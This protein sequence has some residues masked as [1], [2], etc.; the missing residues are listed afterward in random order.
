MGLGFLEVHLVTKFVIVCR[1]CFGFFRG[2]LSDQVCSR[3]SWPFLFFFEVHLLTKLVVVCHG[4]FGFFAV[5]LLT[6]FVVFCIVVFQTWPQKN[7]TTW[8]QKN[9][10]LTLDLKSYYGHSS[11]CVY[12]HI[13]IPST[14]KRTRWRLKQNY[15]T[16]FL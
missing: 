11:F 5:H 8:P 12:C 1:C 10:R 2:A 3:L 4:C 16:G 13:T 9:I 6:K 14:T 7:K 15:T